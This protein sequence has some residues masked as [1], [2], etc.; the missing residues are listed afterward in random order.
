MNSG[1]RRFA[2][3]R[4]KAQA[5]FVCLSKKGKVHGPIFELIY[6]LN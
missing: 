4:Q 2:S 5:P 1:R 6:L 3:P